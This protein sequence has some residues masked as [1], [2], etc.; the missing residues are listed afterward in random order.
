MADMITRCPNCSV[1]FRISDAH[2]KSAKGIVRC[3]SCLGIFNAN[4]HL[5]V[6]QSGTQ[7][8]A[9][10]APAS[11]PPPTQATANTDSTATATEDPDDEL[12]F[13]DDFDDDELI[14][15]SADDETYTDYQPASNLFESNENRFNASSEDD[16]VD[17]ADESWALELLKDDS[18]LD[19]KFRKI[20]TP[21]H[22]QPST[23]KDAAD[24]RDPA[25]AA[26]G[27]RAEPT[28]NT[29]TGVRSADRAATDATQDNPD[30]TR[31]MVRREVKPARAVA[32]SAPAASVQP[33]PSESDRPP[34]RGVALHTTRVRRPASERII[35]VDRLELLDHPKDELQSI[36]KM[37]AAIEPESVDVSWRHN[38]VLWRKRLTGAGLALAALLFFVVQVAWLQFDRLNTVE[39]YRSFYRVACAVTGCTLS[40]MRDRSQIKTTNLYVRSHP[41][42]QGALLIDVVMQNVA[43]FEQSFPSLILTFSNLK[44]EPIA[45]RKFTPDEY[46]GGELSGSDA[47]PRLTP[48]HVEL[49]IVDPGDDAVSYSIA[50][51]D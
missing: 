49:E 46:L 7:T 25:D 11:P 4:E 12:L 3:G 47:M 37:I 28:E 17:D 34:A 33:Q 10:P 21:D 5:Q 8:S 9:Q 51:V 15:D 2:L 40:P 50:I 26:A 32:A 6:V 43:T 13:D 35:E 45:E 42:V 39:P 41:D 1:A 48:V 36:Q 23:A 30:K 14:F 20:V 16:A 24:V 27:S 22:H 38:P 18:D 19:I 29:T 31:F 44:N